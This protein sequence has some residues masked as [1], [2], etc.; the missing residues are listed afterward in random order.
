MRAPNDVLQTA[1]A[2]S[3]IAVRIVL[4]A[5]VSVGAFALNPLVGWQWV[6]VIL[7]IVAAV[8]PQTFAAWGGVACIVIGMLVSEPDLGRAMLAVLVVHAI[9]VLTSLTLVISRGSRVVLAALRPTAARF[10]LVQAIAQSLTVVVML[11]ADGAGG[12]VPWAVVA[13]AVAVVSAAVLLLVN[14]NRSTS[15]E[16]R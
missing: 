8:F 13:G 6:A 12:S 16:R 10:V 9:H 14:A 2:V 15:A 3:W 7:A 11:G 4:I 5:V 1:P